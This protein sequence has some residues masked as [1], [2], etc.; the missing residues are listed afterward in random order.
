MQDQIS[1]VTTQEMT[2]A[3]SRLA[4]RVAHG[5]LPNCP[6][7]DAADWVTVL[8]WLSQEQPYLPK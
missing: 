7:E 1:V 5:A 4:K 8:R 6:Q 2:Q 3:A